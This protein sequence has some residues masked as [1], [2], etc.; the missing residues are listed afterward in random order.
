MEQFK[1]L[2]LEIEVKVIINTDTTEDEEAVKNLFDKAGYDL[3]KNNLYPEG[4][5]QFEQ[6][7]NDADFLILY[8]TPHFLSLTTATL[9]TDIIARSKSVRCFR[10]SSMI[11]IFLINI[12]IKVLSTQYLVQ[13]IRALALVKMLRNL[14]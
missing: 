7:I 5:A 12:V 11:T 10:W 14:H 13:C 4:K 3:I 1:Q 2:E 8:P 9:I 6:N